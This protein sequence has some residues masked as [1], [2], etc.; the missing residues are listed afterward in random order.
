MTEAATT[1]KPSTTTGIRMLRINASV[2]L[3]CSTPAGLGTGRPGNRPGS[4]AASTLTRENALTT[5]QA[6]GRQRGEGSRPLGKSR[7][8]KNSS[9]HTMPAIQYDVQLT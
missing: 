7:S 3:A 8:A 9:V 6:T 1:K 4:K 5:I 2:L